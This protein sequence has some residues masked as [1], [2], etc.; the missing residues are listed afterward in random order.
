MAIWVTD[1]D[2]D[3]YRDTG[4]TSLCGGMHCPSASNE[5]LLYNLFHFITAVA[6]LIISIAVNSDEIGFAAE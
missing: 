5:I 6:Y 2:A 1:P 4:K 3:L